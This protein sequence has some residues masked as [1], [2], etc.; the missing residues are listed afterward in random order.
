MKKILFWSL[1]V[2]VV[3]LG[4]P[5]LMAVFLVSGMAS[6]WKEGVALASE[7]IDTGR[8]AEVLGSR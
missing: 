4:M 3:L 6:S 5:M 8:A 1:A 2:A 7:S